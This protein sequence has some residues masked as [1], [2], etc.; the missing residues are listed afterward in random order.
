M[1][2]SLNPDENCNNAIGNQSVYGIG[3]FVIGIV[4]CFISI[5]W[6][7]VITSR[8]IAA[9]LGNYSNLGVINVLQGQHSKTKSANA[10]DELKKHT[11]LAIINLSFVSILICF[12]VAMIM[13]DW[14][15]ITTNSSTK[16]P[17]SGNTSM[18]MQAVGAWVAAGLYIVGLLIPSFSIL[19]E[20]I[21]ELKF[22]FI[23]SN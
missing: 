20:S 16:S 21:W 8:R 2:V 23:Q 17:T 6:I 18:W 10:E 9:L 12:Y 11:R 5:L 22:N 1:A 19:P 15:T 4:M 7:S 3:Q 13:T 14:G